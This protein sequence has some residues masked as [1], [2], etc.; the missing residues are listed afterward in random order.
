MDVTASATVN[1]AVDGHAW[2]SIVVDSQDWIGNEIGLGT[3]SGI[4]ESIREW[5]G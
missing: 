5:A 2:Y 3:E 1:G 4:F